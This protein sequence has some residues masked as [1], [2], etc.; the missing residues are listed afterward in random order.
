MNFLGTEV[1]LGEVFSMLVVFFKVDPSIIKTPPY[2]P[3]SEEEIERQK[4]S[5]VYGP[6]ET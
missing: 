5:A 3:P 2:V 4:Q 1:S 6:A